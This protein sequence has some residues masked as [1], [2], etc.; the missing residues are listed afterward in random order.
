MML[1]HGGDTLDS[2]F[3]SQQQ[4][5]CQNYPEHNPLEIGTIWLLFEPKRLILYA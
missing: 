5:F 1:L 2:S 4:N 3:Q